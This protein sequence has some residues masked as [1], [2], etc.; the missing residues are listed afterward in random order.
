MNTALVGRAGIVEQVWIGTRAAELDAAAYAGDLVETDGS[1][2]PG[3][4]LVGGVFVASP[5]RIQRKALAAEIKRR[6]DDLFPAGVREMLAKLGGEAAVAVQAYVQEVARVGQS[7]L[8]ADEIPQD[9]RDDRHWPVVPSVTMPV[10][11]AAT[12]LAPS[13]TVS[14][15]FHVTPGAAEPAQ[16]VVHQIERE[17]RQGPADPVSPVGE[18]LAPVAPNYYPNQPVAAVSAPVSKQA[19]DLTPVDPYR[20]HGDLDGLKAALLEAARVS[21]ESVEPK[22]SFWTRNKFKDGLATKTVDVLSEQTVEGVEAAASRLMAYIEGK[23]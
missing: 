8:L 1:I 14:P 17:N 4:R 9:Y 21:F 6:G 23:A 2:A 11:V 3:M 19:Q 16:V 5:P 20:G 13:V 22:L 15:V 7:M 18:K 10:P 12:G